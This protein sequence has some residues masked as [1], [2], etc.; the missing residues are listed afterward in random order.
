V[1][2]INTTSAAFT[3]GVSDNINGAWSSAGSF[4]SAFNCQ[5]QLFYFLNASAGS[6][7]LTITTSTSAVV[8]LAIAEYSGIA[9]SGA[10]DVSPTGTATTSGAAFA[11]PNVTT[12]NANDLIL[13]C[14]AYGGNQGTTTV[15]SP[16]VLRVQNSTDGTLFGEQI[17][18]S[19]GTYTGATFTIQ[20]TG[21]SGFGIISTWKASGG[22]FVDTVS[23]TM[24]YNYNG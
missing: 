20:F 1:D 23:E 3:L 14:L 9:S 4:F 2:P 10:I 24:K 19:T 21:S 15:S 8:G 12:L 16:Y 11:C 5:A 17:V 18:S 22:S 13:A 6:P 7:T